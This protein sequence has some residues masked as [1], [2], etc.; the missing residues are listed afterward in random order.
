[1]IEHAL[2]TIPPGRASRWVRICIVV[3][4]VHARAVPQER[5]GTELSSTDCDLPPQVSDDRS[6]DTGSA[7]P[8]LS[9][10]KVV[11]SGG[12]GMQSERGLG[13]VNQL[14]DRLG[15]AVG[16]SRAVVD[17][18]LAPNELQVGQTGKVVAP[19]L[20]VAVGI[21]G[22]IQHVA[23]MKDSKTIVAINK[24]PEAPIFK[25]RMQRQQQRIHPGSIW[26]AP[27]HLST[28]SA[29]AYSRRKSSI[30]SS[31]FLH[32]KICNSDPTAR[33]QGRQSTCMLR[34][35]AYS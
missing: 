16:A 4:R 24:D 22:A 32:Y 35:S 15:G 12:R 30:F 33:Q 23:G 34:S 6:A 8:D 14:A 31:S 9:T 11:V 10:A 17:A 29:C 26:R 5:A 25:A 27:G 21:S 13:L 28:V 1:M 20:Y 3:A 2:R 19:E 18:G 7:R